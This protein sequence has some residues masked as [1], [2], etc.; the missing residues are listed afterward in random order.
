M[1]P[2]LPGQLRVNPHYTKR[3]KANENLKTKRAQVNRLRR[4]VNRLRQDH[5]P[6]MELLI[7]A[8]RSLRTNRG[9]P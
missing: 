1:S 3:A 5:E 9:G 6:N 8:A 2:G 7:L 4:N